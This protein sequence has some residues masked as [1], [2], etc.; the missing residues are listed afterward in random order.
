MKNKYSLIINIIGLKNLFLYGF[1]NV[2]VL[3]LELLSFT[4]FIPLL[5]ALTNKGELL[6][7]EFFI[8]IL[9]YFDIGYNDTKNILIL[10]FVFL[11]LVFFIKNLFIGIS[12]YYQYKTLS[13]LE[14]NLVS[15]VF[16]KYL[17]RP[18]LL[19]TS[20]NS[21]EMIRNIIGET[22]VFVRSFLGSVLSIIIEGIILIG[23]SIVLYLNEPEIL[24]KLLISFFILG[25]MFF[26]FFN[27]KYIRLGK[28]RQFK[29]KKRLEYLQQ[30]LHGLKEIIA[31]NLQEFILSLFNDT[32]IKLLK[33]VNLVGF[34]NIIPKLLLETLAIVIIL[35][36][37][38]TTKEIQE[39]IN[40]HIF[41][42]GLISVAAFRVFPAIN[43]LLL[44]L[45][46][47]H[48]SKQ[49][50]KVLT[51]IFEFDIESKNKKILKEENLKTSINF[52]K[53]IEIKNLNF[54]YSPQKE[55][56]F[57]NLNIKINKGEHVGI[58]GNTGSGKSTLVNLLLGIFD[59]NEGTI[60]CDGVNIS[61][62]LFQWRN[63]IGYVSQFPYLLDDTIKANV[64]FGV[65]DSKISEKQVYECLEK[66]NLKNFV[67][68]L[69]DG[70]NTLVGERGAQ[71]SG[72]QIQRMAIARAYYKKPKIL[73]LDEATSSVDKITQKK[74]IEYFS[75]F[76]DNFTIISISHDKD[77]LIY[78]D[79]IYVLED[80]NLILSQS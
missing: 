23:I 62:N 71:L 40:K 15:V 37:F 21:S 75:R 76:K 22:S 11:V 20:E 45:N 13:K 56:I 59:P 31:F 63:L 1:L 57:K 77:A 10:I 41:I 48:Y 53:D 14:G 79:R 16:Q 80:N 47:F 74:I 58:M 3:V 66:A 8:K 70:I 25:L 44:A 68:E 2:V 17:Q 61:N 43:K 72:G 24:L 28:E 39:D 30:G 26:F 65:E 60:L 69:K 5:L 51:K 9:D 50:V 42:L 55:F 49:S 46:I 32:N 12:A 18:Y 52:E 19:H 67:L 6:N 35:I 33:N 38:L 27:K 64:A 34:I 7:N 4:M 73:I 78:C 36:I 54:R 29:E